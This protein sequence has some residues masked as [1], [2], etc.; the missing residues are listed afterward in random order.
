MKMILERRDKIFTREKYGEI[1]HSLKQA[2]L[3]LRD[4]ESEKEERREREDEERV[5]GGK[6]EKERI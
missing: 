2:E 6:V 3:L 1:A 4:A 5:R